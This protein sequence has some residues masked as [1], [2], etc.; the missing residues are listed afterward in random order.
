MHST[1]ICYEFI[2][3][4]ISQ[5]TLNNRAP[6]LTNFKLPASV[7][8][9]WW[10]RSGVT[11]RKLHFWV[12][13]GEFFLSRVTLEFD[14]W[15]CITIGHLFFLTWRFAHHFL[16]IGDLKLELQSAKYKFGSKFENFCDLEMWQMTLQNNSTPHLS[17]LQDCSWFP[18]HGW[19]QTGV[20]VWKAQIWV[21]T[22]RLT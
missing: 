12:K 16:A 11:V 2:F 3:L 21:M 9:H 14:G 10:I 17:Y 18:S 4:K 7:R 1:A 22:I 15:P 5:M 20:T 8:I 19:F 13:I 6:L